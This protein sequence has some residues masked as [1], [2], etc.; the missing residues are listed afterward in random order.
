[1][2]IQE[3][4]K[5]YDEDERLLKDYSHRIEY[6]TTLEMIRKYSGN[7]KTILDIG[8]GT[9]LYSMKMNKLTPFKVMQ[10]ILES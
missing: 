1:M 7:V 5:S 3:Y 10:E 2:T 8:A 4:Y 6:D 9:G